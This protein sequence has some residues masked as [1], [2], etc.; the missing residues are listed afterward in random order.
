MRM[1]GQL[2]ISLP[3]IYPADIFPHMRNDKVFLVLLK[4]ANDWEQPKYP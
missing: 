4:I 1:Y 3:G 2:P